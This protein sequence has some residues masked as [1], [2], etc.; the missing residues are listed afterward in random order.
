MLHLLAGLGNPGTQYALTRHNTGF[1]V[2]DAISDK[3]HFP[4]F[5]KK[6]NVL[7]SI[8]NIESYKVILVKPWTFMNNS[9][10]P[11]MS[12]VSL[13]KIPLDNMIVFHDEVE[14]EFCT[15]R[16]KKSGGN[17]GHNGLKS[18]DNFLG[19]DYWRVRF[20]IGHPRDKMDLSHYVL[21]HFHNLN[22]V[23][24]TI[25]NIVEHITLLLEKNHTTFTDKIRNPLKYEDIPD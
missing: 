8:G 1:M 11:I 20:G 10:A 18:I 4:D 21:S 24:N 16:V 5:K 7:I 2:I 17:A 19:K 15:I 3:F 23:N 9:G 14:I 12:V 22:A 13:Y 6:N 25:S